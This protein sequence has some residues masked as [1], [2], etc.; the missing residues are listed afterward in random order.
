MSFGV[1]FYGFDGRF[2]AA[3]PAVKHK[4]EKKDNHECSEQN[5]GD[6]KALQL[7]YLSTLYAQILKFRRPYET[8]CD[9]LQGLIGTKHTSL[10]IV[11]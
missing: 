10:F 7:H 9:D 4:S 11:L 8:I 6:H 3:D 5:I 1:I 2:Q